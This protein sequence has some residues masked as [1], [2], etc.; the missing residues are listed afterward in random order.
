[1]DLD[2]V[3]YAFSEALALEGKALSTFMTRLRERDATTARYVTELF[4]NHDDDWLRDPV[5]QV[6]E[7]LA[8]RPSDD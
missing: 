8:S 6:V 2:K 1:M 5:T 3:E 4:A 7:S